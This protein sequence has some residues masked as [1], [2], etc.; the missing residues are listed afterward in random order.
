MMAQFGTHT[1]VAVANP[2]HS[3]RWSDAERKFRERVDAHRVKLKSHV[4][5]N[6]APSHFYFF[7]ILD[8]LIF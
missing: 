3:R 2:R 7:S 8:F 6:C 1:S 4:H 5:F